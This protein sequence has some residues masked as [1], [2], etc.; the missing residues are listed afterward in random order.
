MTK[1][2]S[3][4]NTVHYAHHTRLFENLFLKE[5]SV[6]KYLLEFAVLLVYVSVFRCLL[7]KLFSFWSVSFSALD[8]QQRKHTQIIAN[9][10]IKKAKSIKK[11]VANNSFNF[12]CKQIEEEQPEHYQINTWY[13]TGPINSEKAILLDGLITKYRVRIKENISSHVKKL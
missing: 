9:T 10:K 4:R 12:F 6:R 2:H 8:W 5:N 3:C 11:N 13:K 1:R 7:N